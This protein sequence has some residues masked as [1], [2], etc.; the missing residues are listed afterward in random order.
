MMRIREFKFFNENRFWTY[1][2]GRLIAISSI[3]TNSGGELR[4][5]LD[6]KTHQ[7]ICQ[8]PSIRR[9]NAPEC[10]GRLSLFT[11]RI[12]VKNESVTG[13][14]SNGVAT[15]HAGHRTWTTKNGGSGYNEI[16]RKKNIP[17]LLPQSGNCEP[18]GVYAKP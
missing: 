3:E 9:E 2:K 4:E 7:H 14:H 16:D 1:D 10:P 5:Q 12:A 13:N 15:P 8:S 11:R 6:D 17:M 18:S